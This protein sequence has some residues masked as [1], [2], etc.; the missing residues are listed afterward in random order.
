MKI[1]GLVELEM[2]DQLSGKRGG[3]KTNNV[4]KIY[5]TDTNS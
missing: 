3:V 2:I 4:C 5:N 1:E